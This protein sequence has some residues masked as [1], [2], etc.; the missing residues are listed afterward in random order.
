MYKMR[1]EFTSNNF[2][3]SL[4]SSTKYIPTQDELFVVCMLDKNVPS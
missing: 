3:T 2:R 4:K 1:K